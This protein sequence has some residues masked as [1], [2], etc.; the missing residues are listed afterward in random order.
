[1]RYALKI[2]DNLL[3]EPVMHTFGATPEVCY[4]EIGNGA[5]EVSMGRWFFEK[6]QLDEVAKVHR[7]D[8]PWYGGLGVRLLGHGTVGV[9]GSHENIV[10]VHFKTPQKVH[11]IVVLECTELRVSLEDPDGFMRELTERCH[12]ESV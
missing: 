4:V 5:L 10:A 3:L 2:T 7:T 6:M 12:L 1:M 11:A 8:W 9:V